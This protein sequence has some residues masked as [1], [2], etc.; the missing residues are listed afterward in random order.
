MATE[1]YSKKVILCSDSLL[2]EM[3]SNTLEGNRSTGGFFSGLRLEAPEH[4][5]SRHGAIGIEVG[6]SLSWMT[7][8]N[9]FI[10]SDALRFLAR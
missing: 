10:G 8:T 4:R 7:I 2:A 9:V 3:L 6:P 5:H 1:M